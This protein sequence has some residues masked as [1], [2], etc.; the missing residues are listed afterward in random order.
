MPR[1][2]VKSSP[3]LKPPTELAQFFNDPPLALNE[4]REDYE[5]LFA[6]IAGAAKPADAIAWLL[7]RDFTDLSWEIQREKNLK[8]K[9]IEKAEE[10]AVAD[11]HT[12][13]KPDWAE[14]LD[15][16]DSLIPGRDEAREIARRWAK[17]PKIR[18]DTDHRLAEEGYNPMDILSA[19]Y[20]P[21]LKMRGLL[22]KLMGLIDGSPRTNSAAT[23][24][25]GRLSNTAIN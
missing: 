7:V 5:N 21:F 10:R 14:S 15:E 12:P 18:R 8:R 20:S 25:Y 17:N 6:A 11:L 9:L 2:L 13:D 16:D 24:Y 1:S 3:P 4:K 19:L 22:F 23:R